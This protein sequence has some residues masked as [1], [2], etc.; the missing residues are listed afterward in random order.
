MVM[1]IL[2]PVVE[3][4]GTCAPAATTNIINKQKR[5]IDLLRILKYSGMK[6]Q[7]QR[8][9]KFVP[10]PREE[11]TKNSGTRTGIRN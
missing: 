3:V 11:A 10:L 9:C 5:K 6:L 8:Q 2:Y 1:G 4:L 7:K